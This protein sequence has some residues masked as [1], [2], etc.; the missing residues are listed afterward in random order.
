MIQRG[1][2]LPFVVLPWAV[3]EHRSLTATDVLV[4]ATI[5]RFA[6]SQTGQA[7]PSRATIAGLARCST[8]TVDRSIGTLVKAGFL[9]KQARRTKAGDPDSNLY[10]VH[11]IAEAANGGVAAPVTT[12]TRTSDDQGGLTSDDLTRT[13]STRSSED[14]EDTSKWSLPPDDVRATLAAL[15]IGGTK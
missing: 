8:S 12:P 2:R 3:L 6:D 11:E 1:R 10:L 13:S 4:Y 15:G 14:T 9:S 5:A 7:Y